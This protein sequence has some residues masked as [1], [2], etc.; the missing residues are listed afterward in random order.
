MALSSSLFLV[1]SVR[2]RIGM[3]FFLSE[4]ESAARGSP[5]SS[6]PSSK[7]ATSEKL[8]SNKKTTSEYFLKH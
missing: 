4:R 6:N 8:T 3:R 7:K 1:S 2:F 5:E